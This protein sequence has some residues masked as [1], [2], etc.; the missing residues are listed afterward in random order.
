[1]FMEVNKFYFNRQQLKRYIAF[2]YSGAVSVC[3]PNTCNPENF[4]S[5]NCDE[6]QR[7]IHIQG[8]FAGGENGDKSN[9]VTLLHYLKIALLIQKPQSKILG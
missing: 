6:R 9:L 1:M 3:L 2:V 8:V 5:E 4:T 7:K